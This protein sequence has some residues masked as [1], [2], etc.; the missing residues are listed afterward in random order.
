[1]KIFHRNAVSNVQLD[2][3]KNRAI[4]SFL[5][6][7]CLWLTLVNRA[8]YGKNKPYSRKQYLL[9]HF[10]CCQREAL[11]P[12]TASLAKCRNKNNETD[13]VSFFPTVE[14]S[15]DFH[16]SPCKPKVFPVGCPELQ[17]DKK[18]AGPIA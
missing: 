1:M 6:R 13:L 4:S 7:Y 17:H 18:L 11:C 5:V 3:W 8:A 10:I 2:I 12:C 14:V 15:R 9:Q 16:F